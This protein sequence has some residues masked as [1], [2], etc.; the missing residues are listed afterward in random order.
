MQLLE[1]SR[2]D[3]FERVLAQELAKKVVLW[4]ESI[5]YRSRKFKGEKV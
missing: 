3:E 1:T 4:P 5:L 2:L